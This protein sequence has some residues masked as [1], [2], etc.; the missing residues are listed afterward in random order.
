M[1]LK[2]QSVFIDDVALAAGLKRVRRPGET[3]GYWTFTE[4]VR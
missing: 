3:N 1:L 4:A 2:G